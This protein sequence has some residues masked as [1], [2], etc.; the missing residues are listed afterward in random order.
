[1]VEH[2]QK[3]AN[4][5]FNLQLLQGDENISKKGKDPENWLREYFNNSNEA[6]SAYKQ[7]NYID[8]NFCLDWGNI[9]EFDKM[10]SEKLMNELKKIF[11]AQMEKTYENNN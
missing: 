1:L 11:I 2:Y 3:K 6:I 8:N 7:R 9:E 10:R 5:L 4:F